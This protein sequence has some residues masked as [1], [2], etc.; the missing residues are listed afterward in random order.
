M[1]KAIIITHD[2]K[3]YQRLKA[4][5]KDLFPEVDVSLLLE[6]NRYSEEDLINL[7]LNRTVIL[8]GNN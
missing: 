4:L 7:F 8:R 2:K 1:E 3:N 5:I 6:D